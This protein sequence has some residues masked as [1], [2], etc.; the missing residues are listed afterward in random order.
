MPIPRF[1][2]SRDQLCDDIR[3]GF[4][5]NGG[6]SL[7]QRSWLRRAIE[8]CP[9]KKAGIDS[10]AASCYITEFLNEDT[11]FSIILRGLN[12]P[13]PSVYDAALFSLEHVTMSKLREHYGPVNETWKEERLSRRWVP[14]HYHE[15]ME[16]YRHNNND[17]NSNTSIFVPIGI[18]QPWSG[19][20]ANEMCHPQI[21]QECKYLRHIIL[22][23]K[24]GMMALAK[25]E[26]DGSKDPCF[27]IKREAL[28]DANSD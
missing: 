3:V 21:H 10:T 14:D 12:A 28:A 17:S 18:H 2:S 20:N 19:L 15:Y 7:R 11:Y 13:F 4:H 1:P 25:R 8:Y 16:N 23:S 24:G 5:G 9:N 22:N 27:D 26:A 6:L